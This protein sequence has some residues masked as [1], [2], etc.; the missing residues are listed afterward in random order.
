MRRIPGEG[1]SEGVE[2]FAMKKY[3]IYNIANIKEIL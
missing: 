1:L 2:G 3:Q